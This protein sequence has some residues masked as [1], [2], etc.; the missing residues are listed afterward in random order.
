ML[1]WGV[2]EKLTYVVSIIV[3]AHTE[4]MIR[5][6]HPARTMELGLTSEEGLNVPTATSPRSRGA[7]LHPQLL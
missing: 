5:L 6:R 7:V 4:A 1:A 3:I 2:G